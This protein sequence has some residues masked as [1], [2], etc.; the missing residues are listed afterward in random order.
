MRGLNIVVTCTS[1]KRLSASAQLMLRN[2]GPRRDISTRAARWIEL[3]E[4]AESPMTPACNM[5]CGEHWSV[6][7]SLPEIALKRGVHTELWVC[8]AGYG[9]I[10]G[11]SRIHSYNATFAT[12]EEDS[13][14]VSVPLSLRRDAAQH[15]WRMLSRW[16][17]PKPRSP[18]TIAGIARKYPKTPL[19]IVASPQYLDA[20][21][22]DV[23]AAA[24]ALVN[25]NF[26]LIISS[27][28]GHSGLLRRHVL[29]SDARFQA[30]VGGTRASLNV[31]VARLLLRQSEPDVLSLPKASQFLGRALEKQPSVAIYSRKPMNDADLRRFIR[32]STRGRSG[33][34][35]TNL[36]RELRDSGRACEQRRFRT[37]YE[38]TVGI[39]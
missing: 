5:Y 6:V 29:P 15:W 31:R 32:Q 34:S 25:T 2:V 14:T 36:L 35:A 26:L 37:L 39:R 9:L 8:S 21:E 3:L 18:R 30:L 17:G 12:N 28:Y 1:R 22:K 38:E 11:S 7:R 4:T 16:P 27:G 24:L 20:I 10:T 33:T 23:L 13:V 19:L